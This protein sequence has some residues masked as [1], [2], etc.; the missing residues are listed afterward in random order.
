[1][2][3][4]R[5]Q[6]STENL[7]EHP[8]TAERVAVVAG[9]LIDGLLRPACVAQAMREWQVSRRTAQVYVARAARRI[10]QAAQHKDPLFSLKL[11]QVQRAKLLNQLSELLREPNFTDPQVWKLKLQT[12]QTALKALDS[13]D[14]AAAQIL[15][16]PQPSQSHSPRPPV[17]R[18]ECPPAGPQMLRPAQPPVQ[19]AEPRKPV[20][21][22]PPS[23][24]LSEA[25]L[26]AVLG[27]AAQGDA[28]RISIVP[29]ARKP[30]A[31]K[32]KRHGHGAQH[33]TALGRNSCALA[34][35]DIAKVPAPP[36]KRPEP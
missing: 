20:P 4:H 31:D 5:E 19:Q 30:N 11:S 7:S 13:S 2:N 21:P 25:E 14:R 28:G 36:A 22:V 29:A 1:M 34:T 32:E 26:A 10:A 9:W 23:R 27:L 12:I 15:K 6:A 17:P 18:W 33:P 24:E 3:Q 16:S 35:G 8:E